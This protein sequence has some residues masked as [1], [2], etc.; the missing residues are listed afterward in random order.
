MSCYAVPSRVL[1]EPRMTSHWW[2]GS[3]LV[4]LRGRRLRARS[5]ALDAADGSAHRQ[6]ELKN[7]ATGHVRGCPDLAA[8][9]FDD[10]AADRQSHPH[11]AALGRVER[12]EQALET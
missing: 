6:G 11:A 9:R 7:G 5:S 8:M 3:P 1:D 2:G 10:R 4:F 12:I